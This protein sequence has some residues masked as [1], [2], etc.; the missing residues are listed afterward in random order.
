MAEGN[1][2]ALAFYAAEGFTEVARRRRYYRDG[3]DAVVMQRDL[4]ASARAAAT[5]E[6]EGHDR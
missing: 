3:A 2:A 6:N 5:G 4:P 1:A